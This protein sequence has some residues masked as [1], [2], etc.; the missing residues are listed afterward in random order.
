MNEI[1]IFAEMEQTKI[2]ITDFC[3]QEAR[4]KRELSKIKNK[5]DNATCK[6]TD[7]GVELSSIYRRERQ[8]KIITGMKNL[9][10]GNSGKE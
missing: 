10:D 9:F 5:L 6:M 3:A 2:E 4:L 8:E 7:L 1:N